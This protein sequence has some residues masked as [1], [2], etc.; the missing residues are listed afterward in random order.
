MKKVLSCIIMLLLG[1]ISCSDTNS[2][3]IGDEISGKLDQ[4][5][6]YPDGFSLFNL[7]HQNGGKGIETAIQ[8]D[9]KIVVMGYTYDDVK[10]YILVLRYN[11]NGTL[12]NTFGTNGYVIF[13]GGGVDQKGLGL[14][15]T[16]DGAIIVTGY[17]K[18]QNQRD[19]LV[20]K[21]FPTGVLDKIYSY[22]SEGE[23]TDI[24]F[25]VDVQADGKIIVVGEQSNGDNQDVILLRLTADLE[26]DTDFG[27]GGVVTY[28]GTGNKNDKGFAVVVQDDGKIVV[29]GAHIA[30]GQEKQD[31]LVLRFCSDGKLDT[32][33]GNGGA[34]TYSHLGDNADYGNFVALQSNGEIVVAG[35]SY[36]GESFKI[37]LLRLNE[38]GSLDDGFG[39]GG[40]TIYQG[41]PSVFDYAFGVAIQQNGKIVVAGTSNNG[42][43]DDAILLRYLDNGTL[44]TGFAHRGLF[45]FNGI[46]DSEDRAYGIAIQPDGKLV[47]TGYS[48]NGEAVDAMTF[49]LM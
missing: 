2:I 28:N 45:T 4:T 44:D 46:A 37:L 38:E 39:T 26:P 19:I 40:V 30:E 49:R 18:L 41:Q 21:Y 17:I 23:Y 6:N 35:A 24:G 42:V 47:V 11:T 7:P 15:L 36:D 9:G 22:S 34:F 12:D 14:A 8:P 27:D 29:G 10:N 48:N 16:M 20:L 31:V 1:L 13:D 3:P 32:D 43:N 25:G 33:F 5:F